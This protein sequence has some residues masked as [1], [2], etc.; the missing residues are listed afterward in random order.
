[1]VLIR[2]VNA[3]VP[4]PGSPVAEF[5]PYARHI[6]FTHLRDANGY[7]DPQ[8]Y[9]SGPQSDDGVLPGPPGDHQRDMLALLS[10]CLLA[11]LAGEAMLRF[12]AVAVL[13]TPGV[14]APILRS[15][16]WGL[17]RF[18]I[19]IVHGLMLRF[20]MLC[21]CLPFVIV[22]V[23]LVQC[24]GAGALSELGLPAQAVG[25]PGMIA[26]IAC[27]NSIL[28]AAGVVYDA[29]LYRA[30]TAG[31]GTLSVSASVP[32]PRRASATAAVRQ[33]PSL[34]HPC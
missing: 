23:V 7:I 11:F 33:H 20:A 4:D 16:W 29:R 9:A 34:E 13:T 8:A 31:A 32:Q 22:P 6:T 24:F 1:V 18:P 15:A 2:G 17:T 12:R 30:M 5:V 10:L 14:I 19:L 21:I 3:L 27:V 25:L 28:S 26:G